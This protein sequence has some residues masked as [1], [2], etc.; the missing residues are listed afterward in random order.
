MNLPQLSVSKHQ[1]LYQITQIGGAIG[2]ENLLRAMFDESRKFWNAAVD[3]ASGAHL[4]EGIVMNNEAKAAAITDYAL[5]LSNLF[6]TSHYPTMSLMTKRAYSLNTEHRKSVVYRM[7]ALRFNN[8]V[9]LFRA[10]V[11]DLLCF[12]PFVVSMALTDS[13]EEKTR[14]LTKFIA[15][16]NGDYLAEEDWNPTHEE[17]FENLLTI[18]FHEKREELI[19]ACLQNSIGTNHGVEI[20]QLLEDAIKSVSGK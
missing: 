15:S 9:E 1:E 8:N 4:I 13:K 6:I 14:L 7:S 2:N 20:Y 19:N 10:I 18:D 17:L 12:D 5:Q 11:A 3:A 16:A